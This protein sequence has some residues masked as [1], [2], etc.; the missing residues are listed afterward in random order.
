LPWT[1]DKTVGEKIVELGR[2]LSRWRIHDSKN[3]GHYPLQNG[4]LT[5][6]SGYQTSLKS[7]W[8][9]GYFTKWKLRNS[10]FQAI[11]ELVYS[12]RT[13]SSMVT[14]VT[15]DPE[16]QITNF[17]FKKANLRRWVWEL[18]NFSRTPEIHQW[19]MHSPRT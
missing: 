11:V 2:H 6:N 19:S 16:L 1:M 9:R 10:I 7:P 12:W 3:S 4:S 14:S 18:T 17:T 13:D 8:W 5:R 15:H